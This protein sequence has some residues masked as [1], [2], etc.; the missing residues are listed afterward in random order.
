MHYNN[1]KTSSAL[2]IW[3]IVGTCQISQFK[4]YTKGFA[5]CKTLFPIS[6]LDFDINCD[7]DAFI[8]RLTVLVWRHVIVSSVILAAMT[9]HLLD[10]MKALPM[11]TERLLKQ[12][13]VLHRPLIREGG[14]VWEIS[15]GFLNVVFMPEEHAESLWSTEDIHDH[16]WSLTTSWRIVFIFVT[17]LL[18]I[19]SML[20][21]CNC[22]VLIHCGEQKET[23]TNKTHCHN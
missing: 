1:E 5:F 16:Q 14:E 3:E 21:F 11:K 23:H 6:P 8:M 22:N 10:P 15:K 2:W 7:L 9:H 20:F 19:V 18:N 4:Y 13:L 12:H 17:H